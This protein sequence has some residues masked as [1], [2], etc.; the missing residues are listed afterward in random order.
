MRSPKQSTLNE[1]V[2]LEAV[3][4]YADKMKRQAE[5]I[6]LNAWPDE[7]TEAEREAVAALNRAEQALRLAYSLSGHAERLASDVFYSYI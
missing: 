1:H 7:P 3:G 4:A 2:N 6:L 5:Q